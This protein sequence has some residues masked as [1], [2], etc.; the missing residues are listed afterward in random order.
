MRSPFVDL[1]RVQRIKPEEADKMLDEINVK[2]S[3]V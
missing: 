3:Y 1:A 2:M